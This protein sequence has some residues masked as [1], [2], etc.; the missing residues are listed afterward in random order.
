MDK[1]QYQLW[2][3]YYWNQDMGY[4]KEWQ[5]NCS[6]FS[7]SF[8]A[9]HLFQKSVN[10]LGMHVFISLPFACI[11]SKVTIA[12]ICYITFYMSIIWISVFYYN[13]KIE[14]IALS[15]YLIVC[16]KNILRHMAN[17]NQNLLEVT[18]WKW[19]IFILK[20]KPWFYNM[21]IPHVVHNSKF[22]DF[23]S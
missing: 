8:T 23:I 2:N 14:V 4:F 17:V 18:K 6:Y 21:R 13:H 19:I 10:L 15:Q 7:F 11:L 3:E 1:Y 22:P 20:D 9:G 5:M 12:N 16:Q